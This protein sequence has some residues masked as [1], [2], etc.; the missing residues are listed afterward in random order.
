MP[1]VEQ[2]RM[3]DDEWRA[4]ADH[5][6]P[7]VARIISQRELDDLG[8]K[9][10]ADCVGILGSD[11]DTQRS[12]RFLIALRVFLVAADQLNVDR[13]ELLFTAQGIE[14]G[15]TENPRLVL[16]VE[17][18]QQHFATVAKA[19]GGVDADFV[20]GWWAAAAAATDAD[21][22]V[23]DLGDAYGVE[24]RNDIRVQVSGRA[25]LVE[26]LRGHRTDRHQSAQ[27]SSSAPIDSK[28]KR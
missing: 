16:D 4:G 13:I 19:A 7:R 23:T 2:R 27:M 11:I 25:D 21:P 9:Q 12:E 6:A 1:A 26:Q 28:P 8:R 5:V 15:I 14:Q 3:V 22:I 17:A 18:R 24:V 20:G 10:P